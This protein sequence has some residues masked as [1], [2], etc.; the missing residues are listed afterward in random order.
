ML[1]DNQNHQ[2]F[3]TRNIFLETGLCSSFPVQLSLFTSWL[4]A[5][6]YENK[7]SYFSSIKTTTKL[8]SSARRLLDEN[9]SRTEEKKKRQNSFRLPDEKQNRQ[10]VSWQGDEEQEG[11]IVFVKVVTYSV[12]SQLS[13]SKK[14]LFTL[15]DINFKM[16]LTLRLQKP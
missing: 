9:T 6:A 3:F 12:T 2:L 1:N 4:A 15:I 10:P 14:R 13:Q 5:L 7:L 16:Y 8:V 11:W